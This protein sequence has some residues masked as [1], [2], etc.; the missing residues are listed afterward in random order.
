MTPPPIGPAPAPPPRVVIAAWEPAALLPIFGEA[1]L[2][3][4]VRLAASEGAAVTVLLTPELSLA[5]SRRPRDAGLVVWRLV[6]R[7]DL[8]VA[9]AHLGGSPEEPVV[10]VPGHSVWDRLSF[11]RA[12]AE[13]GAVWRLPAGQVPAVLARWLTAGPPAGEAGLP[14][15]LSGPGKAAAAE[16]R[17][18]A[19]LAAATQ[20]SDGLL[21]R[22][23]DRPLSR[24]LSPRLAA[25]RVPPNA[26]TMV[27]SS[28]GLL[29]ALLLAQ[30]GYAAHLAGALLFLAAV[31]LDGVDGEVARLSLRE[32]RFGH[33]LDIITDNLV[34]VAVFGGIA[35]G[36]H[37]QA[38]DARHLYALAL[39][40][41]GFALCALAV[42]LVLGRH[43]EPSGTDS[44]AA[45]LV[46]ALNS[47]DFAYLVLLLALA[48]RLHWFLWGAAVGTYVFAGLLL[49]MGRPFGR[50]AGG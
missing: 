8:A 3:R 46:A 17:L 27:G 30:T 16:A 29:G 42:Y 2:S 26:V 36:L 38:P 48:D 37:R 24:C 23:V 7:E 11:R 6:P 34:H 5:L 9:T 47:R 13:A 1:A 21:A 4:L 45:R 28:I 32:S 20:E 15:L 41:V 43:K 49:A 31:V 39:L 12:L 14:V 33:Y 40:L 25:R 44:L 22:W 50:A 10:L 18:V 35:A 19:A